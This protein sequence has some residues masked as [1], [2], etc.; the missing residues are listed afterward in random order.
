MNYTHSGVVILKQFKF[1]VHLT[2]LR[3]FGK[4]YYPTCIRV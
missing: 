2:I 4:H 3:S 1:A